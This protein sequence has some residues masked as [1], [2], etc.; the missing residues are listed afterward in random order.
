MSSVEGG[1]STF[2]TIYNF[3]NALNSQA[4]FI[5]STNNPGLGFLGEE[6]SATQYTAL[7]NNVAY[8]VPTNSGLAPPFNPDATQFQIKVAIR[9]HGLT[10]NEY[11]IFRNVSTT[12]RNMIVNS[13]DEKYISALCH[14]ITRFNTRTT[15]DIMQHIWNTYGKITTSDLTA[16]E[17][18]MYASWNPP[19]LQVVELFLQRS[20][21]ATVKNCLKFSNVGFSSV[22]SSFFAA[23]YE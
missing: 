16:N 7:N 10:V 6:I 5:P 23:L 11:Q 19:T 9:L 3:Q 4:L 13:I 8:V 12:L 17:E 1:R 15:L 18:S 22:F 21:S 2:T 20:S 14:P